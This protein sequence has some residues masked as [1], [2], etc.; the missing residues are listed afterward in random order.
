MPAKMGPG[1]VLQGYVT[2]TI[3]GVAATSIPAGQTPGIVSA[4]TGDFAVVVDNPAIPVTPD[5]ATGNVIPTVASF[6]VTAPATPTQ[7]GVPVNITFS[8]TNADG[9]DAAVPLVDTIE[10]DVALPPT[11][12]LG[13]LF[14]AEVMAA[15]R[16]QRL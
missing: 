1:G 6:K 8:L 16:K 14:G 7:P 4:D 13:D 15:K 12:V 3:D 9:S 2:L 10:V 11:E 5:P